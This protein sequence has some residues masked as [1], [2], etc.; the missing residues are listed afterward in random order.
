MTSQQRNELWDLINKYVES[1]GGNPAEKIYGNTRRQE[2]VYK[3]EDLIINIKIEVELK[4]LPDFEWK[5]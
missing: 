4:Y 3:I 5:T 2:L 1:C